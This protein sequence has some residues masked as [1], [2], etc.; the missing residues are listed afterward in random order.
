MARVV[1]L[2]L[3][4]PEVFNGVS[5][6]VGQ[7]RNARVGTR[8]NHLVQLGNRRFLSSGLHVRERRAPAFGADSKGGLWCD[9]AQWAFIKNA[10]LNLAGSFLAKVF[11]RRGGHV[12]QHL[13][14]RGHHRHIACNKALLRAAENILATRV[15]DTKL[16]GHLVRGR[17]KQRA[18]NERVC[19]W[20]RQCAHVA[21]AGKLSGA[22]ALALNVPVHHRLVRVQRGLLGGYPFDLLRREP[23]SADR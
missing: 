23:F 16:I 1:V 20:V 18:L 4:A 15:K 11:H 22:F 10:A 17:T 9:A 5:H 7:A 12:F 13:C 21:L 19:L 6:L 2:C 14:S 3:G 8:V